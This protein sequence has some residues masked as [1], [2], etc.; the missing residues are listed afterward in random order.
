VIKKSV[1]HFFFVYNGSILWRDQDT[2]VSERDA[3]SVCSGGYTAGR[4]LSLQDQVHFNRVIDIGHCSVWSIF[5]AY[6]N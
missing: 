5:G 6:G 2:Y 1:V 4:S 3:A